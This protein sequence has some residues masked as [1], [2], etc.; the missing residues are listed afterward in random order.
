MSNAPDLGDELPLPLRIHVDLARMVERQKAMQDTAEAVPPGA[1]MRADPAQPTPNRGSWRVRLP[2]AVARWLTSWS[3]ERT[4]KATRDLRI[5]ASKAESAAVACLVLE[6]TAPASSNSWTVTGP[7]A[8]AGTCPI[9]HAASCL[10]L[11][12]HGLPAAGNAGEGK[13]QRGSEEACGVPRTVPGIREPPPTGP[14]LKRPERPPIPLAQAVKRTLRRSGSSS[15]ARRS[16]VKSSPH[17]RWR[18]DDHP[19]HPWTSRLA[20]HNPRP[21]MTIPPAS[22]RELF[23]CGLSAA[24]RARRASNNPPTTRKNPYKTNES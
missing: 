19:Y 2:D 11:R 8:A 10:G 16:P 23:L 1:A 12:G 18:H 17:V 22:I 20:A 24:R 21:D 6:A 9:R 5:R 3:R 15:I 14:A 7:T 13:R 4:S